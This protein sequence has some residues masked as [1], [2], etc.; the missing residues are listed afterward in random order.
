MENKAVE[1]TDTHP[2]SISQINIWN[3]EQAFSGTSINNI[4]ATI[5]INGRLDI[6]VIQRCL[7]MVVESDPTLRTRIMLFDKE[8][9]QYYSEFEPCQYPVYD[10]SLT[11]EAGLHQWETMVAHQSMQVIGSGLCQFFI[12]KLGENS[13]GILMKTHHL[14]SDGWTQVLLSNKIAQTYLK[15]I[16]GEDFTLE[17]APPYHLHI[18]DEVKYIDSKAMERDK[19]YWAEIFS[20]TFEPATIKVCKSAA[21]SPVGQ[22]LTFNLSENLNHS[23]YSFCVKHRVAPFAVLY[24]AL[25][26]YLKRIGGAERSGIGVPI[27]NR[28]NFTDR[29]S[30]GMFV[31]TLPF[32]CDI[33][34]NWSFEQFNENLTE[35]W[36]DLLRHQKLS[37]R[38]IVAIAKQKLDIDHLFHIVLSYQNTRILENKGISVVFSGQWHYSGYQ[39]EHI[40]IHLSNLENERSYQITYDFLA[41]LFSANEIENLHHYIMNILSEALEYPQRPICRLSIIGKK[42]REAVLYTFNQTSKYLSKATLFEHF[43]AAAEDQPERVALICGEH[44]VRYSEL[45][46]CG[47]TYAASINAACGEGKHVIAVFLPKGIELFCS[48]IGIMQ[49][50]NAWLLLSSELP[51]KRIRE[52]IR[53]SGAELVISCSD[54]IKRY[55][56]NDG[57][58]RVLDISAIPDEDVASDQTRAASIN[59]LAYIVYTSGSTGTPKGIEIEQISLINFAQCVSGLY[60]HKAVLSL[61]SVT[62]DAFILEG[63]AALI[64]G[65]TIVLPL[66]ADYE[67]PESL[68]N[69]ITGRGVGFISTT[70]SRLAAYMKHPAFL[71]ALRNMDSIVCGGESFPAD[72]LQKLKLHSNACIYNQYGPS[73]TTVGVA[74]KLLNDS[75]SITIGKPMNNCK[76]Y[77]LDKQLQPLPVG[78]HGEI[79][80]GGLCVGRGY[81]NAPEL[82]AERFLES[83]FEHGERIYRTGDT[84]CWTQSGEIMLKGRYDDQLK[85]RGLRIEPQE[86]AMQLAAHPYV[87]EAAIKLINRGSTAILAAYYTSDRDIET[88]ELYEFLTTYLPSYMIPA[89]IIRL[90]QMPLTCSGKVD[91]NRLPEPAAEAAPEALQTELQQGLIH[92]FNKVLSRDDITLSSDYFACGGDSLNAMETLAGIEAEFGVRLRVAELYALRTPQRLAERIGGGVLVEK[93]VSS[94]RI[95]KAPKLEAYPPTPTQRSLY[96]Q[97]KLDG[98]GLAYNMPGAFYLPE[99]IDIARLKQAFAKLIETEELLRTEFVLEGGALAQKIKASVPFEFEELQGP[100]QSAAAGFVRLFELDKAPLIRAAI[101]QDNGRT[102]LLVDSHHIISDGISTPII[103]KRLDAFYRGEACE[104]PE[105]S[106]KDYAY[107]LENDK[108]AVSDKQRSYW[109]QKAAALNTVLD[110]PT[111]RTRPRT[112]DFSGESYS[113]ELPHNI[114]QSLERY[115]ERSGLS[116]FM[117]LCG[118]FALCLYK[119][120]QSNEFNIGTPVSGRREQQLWDMFGSFIN[121]LPLNFRFEPEMTASEYLQNVKRTVIEMLDN[122]DVPLEEIVAM[123]GVKRSLQQ[124]PLYGVMFAM[125]PIAEDAFKIDGRP[126]EYVPIPTRTSK[127]DLSLEA[128]KTASGYA[129]NFEYATSLFDEATIKLY[130]R[131]FMA[132]LADVISDDSK[133]LCDIQAVS[134]ADRLELFEKPMRRHTP[135][136]DMCIDMQIDGIAEMMPDSPAVICRDEVTTFGQLKAMADGFAAQLIQYGVQKGQH[137]ALSCRRDAKM[138]AAMLGIL[139]AGCAYVPILASFPQKRIAYMLEN[140]NAALIFC[141]D[142]TRLKLPAG[143]PCPV[144]VMDADTAANAAL[145]ERSTDDTMYILYTSGSTGQPKGVMVSHRSVANLLESIRQLIED[146]PGN[147]LCTTNVIF[148]TFITENLLPLA[149]GKCIVMA[150]EEEMMLPWKHGELIHRHSATVMQLTPSRLQVCLGNDAFREAVKRIRLMI[151][152]G[153]MLSMQLVEALR[154]ISPASIINMYGPTEAAVYVTAVDLTSASESVIGKPL[155]NCRIYILDESGRRVMPTARGEIY[156]A[157]EC[158]AKGYVNMPELTRRAFL[159]DPFVPG[160]L[161]YKSGDIGRLKSDGNIDYIGRRDSQVKLHGQR[162][163]LSEITGQILRTGLAVQ[164]ATVAVKYQGSTLKLCAFVVPVQG[165]AFDPEILRKRLIEELPSYM[166]PAEIIQLESLPSTASGKTDLRALEAYDVEANAQESAGALD[167]SSAEPVADVAE[168]KAEPA[169]QTA[170]Q[171][172]EGDIESELVKLWEAALS[173]PNPDPEKSFFEQGGSSLAA[174]NLLSLY[175]NRG[176]TVSLGQFYENPTIKAQAR[177]IKGEPAITEKPQP[178]PVMLEVVKPTAPAM[179]KNIKCTARDAVLLTGATGFLGAHIV[180]ELIES[181]DD[182]IICPIRG[183]N[184]QRLKDV[185]AWYFGKEWLL[186]NQ[187]RFK[188][189]TGDIVSDNIGMSQRDYEEA[190]ERVRCVIH[191]AADVRHYVSDN[192]SIETNCGGTANIIDF[193]YLHHKHLRGSHTQ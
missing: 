165:V 124:N 88:A 4:C 51:K 170:V 26:V 92:T 136:L 49:T 143:L 172:P 62:F 132:A 148:D 3:L 152:A 166:V 114:S 171:A 175:Y 110:L 99:G 80:I 125:R 17:P 30:S 42:E 53:N 145:P 60:G 127:L 115:C 147:V 105:I 66:E 158:L 98:T 77:V 9:R 21:I 163:E 81:R 82:T 93:P 109:K 71:R 177:I 64:N 29:Q 133:K 32:I 84:G 37:Y 67:N 188:V 19:A 40:C 187:R 141:D 108:T 7:N 90:E 94:Q 122:Q 137:V 74:T 87:N 75:L 35:Q 12:Y 180:K 173:K 139:K 192:S 54:Y 16:S 34:D 174:L 178:E 116:A 28:I 15:L 104:L 85:L 113:F 33:D 167:T 61:C 27:F 128:A 162:I 159:P 39:A 112:K 73:E 83:P 45:L 119:A 68:A 95:P 1:Y 24:M 121:T 157:G 151:L 155:N 144:L 52:L 160:Q 150:D 96:M 189:V 179:A 41:Q 2:L 76:L 183:G 126:L 102:A 38:D 176:W 78:V 164:A 18:E 65:R 55:G 89:H 97:S 130:A 134:A 103:L 70:P 193:A 169:P 46:S 48:L 190:A 14:I 184:P 69:L 72:L 79:Y 117:V 25:A 100:L 149:M 5:R 182:E 43:K 135:F 146:V 191:S 50:G 8:P 6:D 44:K 154:S 101:V 186:L 11:N 120:S 153:E 56:L 58:I 63:V 138:L 22:R 185:L 168:I 31:S 129:F 111:D 59:D 161:M 131:S 91:I 10:F 107:W 118:V 23:I 140:S 142:E 57:S 106:Y 36:Y 156:I 86:I 181:C 13:G 20:K 123:A 47:N